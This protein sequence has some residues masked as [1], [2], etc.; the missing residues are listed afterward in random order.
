[1]ARPKKVVQPVEPESLSLADRL[2]A[3][4]QFKQSY[5]NLFL[6]FLIVLVLAVLA[7]NYFK[8]SPV[9]NLGPANQTVAEQTAESNDQSTNPSAAP[10]VDVQTDKLPGKYTVKTGDT[11]S[12]I[13]QKYYNDEGQYLQLA[14]VNKIADPN[15][16]IIG[17]VI[18]IPKLEAAK[19]QA[20]ANAPNTTVTPPTTTTQPTVPTDAPSL[21]AK[22]TGT[23]YTVTAGDWLSTISGRAYG[24]IFSFE[25]IAKANN[26]T[27]PDL[28][29]PGMVLKIPR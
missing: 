12:T 1:M 3:E 15:T 6:G 28:I 17:Q 25:K 9:D 18:D 7:F 5:L 26:I 23:T 8:K 22:I 29:E 4:L 11:L 14:Q 24:D 2:Q 19:D 16:I 10:V 20:Q 27:N 13:A 21:T